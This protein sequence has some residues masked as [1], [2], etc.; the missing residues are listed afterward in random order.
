MKLSIG[1]LIMLTAGC[2]IQVGPEGPLEVIHK[3][4]ISE[5]EKYFEDYCRIENPEYTEI[6][7]ETCVSEHLVKFL[8]NSPL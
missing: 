2:S 1:L 4:D 7:L 8:E 6:E 5:I 3:V